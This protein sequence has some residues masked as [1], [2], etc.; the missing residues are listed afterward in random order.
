MDNEKRDDDQQSPE[1]RR[2]LFLFGKDVSAE[3]IAATLNAER[4]RQ[5]RLKRDR[6]EV[7][8]TDG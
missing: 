4:E 8:E 2:T 5:L 3:E 7:D 6:P 1:S